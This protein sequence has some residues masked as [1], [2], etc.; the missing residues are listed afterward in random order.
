MVK[1][2]SKLDVRDLLDICAM[3]GMNSPGPSG[4]HASSSSSAADPA[5]VDPPAPDDVPGP[6]EAEVPEDSAEHEHEGEVDEA[7]PSTHD[8]H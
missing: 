6:E 2:A 1:K 4:A 8:D 7:E 5:A 3:K